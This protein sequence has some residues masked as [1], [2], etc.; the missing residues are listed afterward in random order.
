MD[1]NLRKSIGHPKTS[2]IGSRK[3]RKITFHLIASKYA[4]GHR[5][6]AYTNANCRAVLLSKALVN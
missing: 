3:L 5:D 2:F 4:F 6:N 1:D